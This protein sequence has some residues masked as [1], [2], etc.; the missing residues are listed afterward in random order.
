MLKVAGLPPGKYDLVASD[1]A[2][3]SFGHDQLA[4]GVNL[5]SATA[6]PWVPGGPWEA[7]A[8][9]LNQ[10]T[11]ARFHLLM[12]TKQAPDYLKH[13]P[14]APRAAEQTAEAN[15]RIEELQRTTSRPVPYHFIVHPTSAQP[16]PK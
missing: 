13:H 9:S 16:P 1:R 5:S 6:D 14:D 11:E 10:L 4:A 12:A 7:Q 8:W 15:S 3:G 2:V